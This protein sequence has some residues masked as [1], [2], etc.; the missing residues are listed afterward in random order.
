M[1]TNSKKKTAT[2]VAHCKVWNTSLMSC[3]KDQSD[4]LACRPVKDSSKSME[5]LSPSFSLKCSAS[6]STSL[7]S[8][9]ALTSSVRLKGH[10][11]RLWDIWADKGNSW[12]GY[13]SQSNRRRSYITGLC[14]STSDWKV[15]CTSV[16]L[17]QLFEKLHRSKGGADGYPRRSHTTRNMSMNT[18]RTS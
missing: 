15:H 16:S 18:R 3:P 17:S 4:A 7:Y 6:R 9:S 10:I 8:S 12:C 14:G 5:S 2:A 1:R 11:G 13:S